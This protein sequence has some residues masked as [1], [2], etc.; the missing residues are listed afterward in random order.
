MLT[1]V[2][3][4]L[5]LLLGCGGGGGGGHSSEINSAPS[6][7]NFSI[8]PSAGYI[9]SGALN[10]DGNVDVS[11]AGGDIASMII[12]VIDSSGSTVS[13]E[14]VT[15]QGA[16][17]VTQGTLQLAA[18]VDTNAV[19][20]GS[21]TVQIH[22]VDS[23]GRS[24]NVLAAPFRL[25]VFPWVAKNT[26]PTARSGFAAAQLNG[27]IYVCGGSV[28][29]TGSIPGPETNMVE[30]FD[31]ATATWSAGPSM[32]TARIGATAAVLGGKLYVIGGDNLLAPGGT[33]IVEQFDPVSGTWSQLT[34]MP[35]ARA[36]AAGV[37]IGT[38]IVVAG[39]ASGGFDVAATEAYDATNGWVAF[40][41][42]TTARENL[43]ADAIN[44]VM[45][46]AGGYAAT[47]LTGYQAAFEAFDPLMDQWSTKAPMPTARQRHA[48]VAVDGLLYVMGGEN[49]SGS[50]AAVDAYHPASNAWSSKTALPAQPLL[51]GSSIMNPSVVAVLVNSKVYLIGASA[52]FEYTPS[53]DI[54]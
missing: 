30:I 40:S 21:Y 15:I 31:P 38:Q 11:D 18:A 46:V 43:A 33:G 50:I 2:V 1:P 28:Q 36:F 14:S 29:N 4:V 24:S 7:S 20:A 27:L 25:S 48:A 47:S 16:Q 37:V 23:G 8:S 3:I 5:F 26:M 51:N 12:A 35:T 52:M 39:G 41:P 6:I 9:A 10:V 19:P 45:Y 17:G 54:Y 13:S 32:P 34:S 42:M 44:G 53:N 22:I 49:G